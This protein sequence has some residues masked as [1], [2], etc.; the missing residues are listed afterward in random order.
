MARKACGSTDGLAILSQRTFTPWP[1]VISHHFGM[2][3]LCDVVDP[4]IG[5]EIEAHL[6]PFVRPGRGDDFRTDERPLLDCPARGGTLPD[7]PENGENQCV[8]GP[9]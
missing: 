6:D 8:L 5:A 2:D 9:W 7:Q 3:V 1:L 4:V